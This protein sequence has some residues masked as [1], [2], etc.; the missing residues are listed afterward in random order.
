VTVVRVVVLVFVSLAFGKAGAAPQFAAK[1]RTGACDSFDLGCVDASP[2]KIVASKAK[3][4]E[5]AT[6]PASLPR[7]F[8]TLPLPRSTDL[9]VLAAR[10]FL[11]PPKGAHVYSYS[12]TSPPAHAASL[13]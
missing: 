12:G 4:P 10:A 9:P 6:A 1:A 5:L 2:S 13:A 8:G 7:G 3:A 11:S